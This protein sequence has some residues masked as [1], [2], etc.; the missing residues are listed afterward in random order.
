MDPYLEGSLWS[1]FHI[2]L[3]V[4][5]SRQ[6]AAQ[7]V[8][9]LVALSNEYIVEDALHYAIE[10]R[11]PRS[12]RVVTAVE[13]LSPITDA[14]N[15]RRDYLTRRDRILNSGTHLVEIDLLREGNQLPMRKDL[16][17]AD[18]YVVV[19]RAEKRPNAEL[20]PVR[21]RDSLPVVPIPLK[22]TSEITLD[23]QRAFQSIYDLHRYDLIIDYCEP[24]ETPLNA[25]DADWAER[26]VKEHLK[27]LQTQK[28]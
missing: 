1:T 24:P 25:D 27:R 23:L 7:V 19:S 20:W 4:E 6:I 5:I 13:L 21:L 11:E 9:D 10:V 3:A 12:R 18:Y 8:P 16:P 15:G 14:G 17:P 28:S 2:Q 22:G 26:I